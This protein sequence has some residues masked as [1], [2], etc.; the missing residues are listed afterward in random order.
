MSDTEPLDLD[1]VNERWIDWYNG[2]S[3]RGDWSRLDHEEEQSHYLAREDVP[4]LMDEVH[5]LREELVTVHPATAER[6]R[7][8]SLYRSEFTENVRL[9][10]QIEEK[11]A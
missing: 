5:R 4:A 2:T 7:Y 1:A 3:E 10:R 11:T 8:R 9:R 6:D